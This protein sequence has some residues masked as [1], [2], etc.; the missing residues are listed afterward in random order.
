MKKTV[1]VLLCICLL[2]GAVSQLG[3]FAMGGQTCD[4]EFVPVIHLSGGHGALTENYGTPEEKSFYGIDKLENLTREIQ[5]MISTFVANIL[6]GNPSKVLDAF[7]ELMDAWVGPLT[8]FPDGSSL[9]ELDRYDVNEETTMNSEHFWPWVNYTFAFDWRQSPIDIADDLH[10]YVQRI[11][12]HT[13]HDKVH[14]QS[15]SGSGSILT[16]Y[17]DKYVNPVAD[18]DALS[19]VIGQS[20]GYGAPIVGSFLNARYT[21]NPRN[22]GALDM[23]YVLDLDEE[24]EDSVFGI[25]N[26]L[27]KSGLLDVF[28]MASSLLPQA[29]FDRIYEEITRKTYAAWPGMWAWCPP[30]DY[31]SAKARLTDGHPEYEQLGFIAKLDAYKAIQDNAGEILQTASQKI[32]VAN[33]V[34]YDMSLLFLDKD[35]NTSSDGVVSAFNASLGAI[36]APFGRT[37]SKNYV[38]AMDCGTGHN[39]LSPDAMVDASTCALPDDTWF[40]KG[41]IHRGLYEYGGW[42]KWWRNAPKGA[43]TVFDNPDF[44]QFMKAVNRSQKD[45]EGMLVPVTAEDFAPMGIFAR[46][47]DWLLQALRSVLAWVSEPW[48]ENA[49]VFWSRWF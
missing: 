39:H 38:Q 15:I 34:G 1:S 28:A 10:E 27:Y 33:M 9:K 44:P 20:T 31:D 24:S 22:L 30:E 7:I 21:V 40:L 5:P 45:D 48:R 32:K 16:T 3:I 17:I 13:G 4:C 37:L 6:T 8:M 46:L 19:V 42:Y 26:T 2:A 25:M 12:A 41:V 11:K 29:A 49:A 36:V 47:W 14:I 35:N 23:L 18:P 43:D